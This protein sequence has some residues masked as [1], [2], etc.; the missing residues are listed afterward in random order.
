MTEKYLR[1]MIFCGKTYDFSTI[2]YWT[3]VNKNENV[4]P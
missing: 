4:D 3:K 1:S 2:K